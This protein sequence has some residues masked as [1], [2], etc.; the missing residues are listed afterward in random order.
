[1]AVAPIW[2]PA[3]AG[4]ALGTILV[5]A[6]SAH[7][8]PSGFTYPPECCNDHDCAMIDPGEVISG[9]GYYVWKDHRIAFDSPKI[10]QS[11]D[12]FFHGCETGHWGDTSGM[13]ELTCFF[14]PQGM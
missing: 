3:M 6:A 13:H 9:P 11:P 14:V 8:A 7:D 5:A 10:R 1:M 12:I 2:K 4:L